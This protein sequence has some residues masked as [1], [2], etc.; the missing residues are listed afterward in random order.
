MAPTGS[1]EPF[2][3]DGQ[4]QQQR[5]HKREQN[6]EQGGYAEQRRSVGFSSPKGEQQYRRADDHARRPRHADHFARIGPGAQRHHTRDG[7]REGNGRRTE[8][9][10]A[11]RPQRFLGQ[12]AGRPRGN[13]SCASSFQ[14]VFRC[15]ILPSAGFASRRGSVFRRRAASSPGP[16]PRRRR[17]AKRWRLLGEALHV[18]QCTS[19]LRVGE[20]AGRHDGRRSKG[21]FEDGRGQR[22]QDDAQEGLATS[23]AST[24][25]V[26]LPGAMRAYTA[27]HSI[28]SMPAPNPST[29]PPA[30]AKGGEAGGEKT[31][32]P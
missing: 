27:A 20:Q 11:Q 9:G 15:R 10:I 13:G 16:L 8:Q 1:L 29:R 31:R 25:G 18:P 5:R 2:P 12:Q 30:H 24:D 3:A 22:P 26:A 17:F 21:G 4:S 23:A 32:R 19:P 14:G 7:R 6:A 28:K